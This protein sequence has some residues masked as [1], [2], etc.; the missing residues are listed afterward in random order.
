MVSLPLSLQRK[1]YRGLISDVARRAHEYNLDAGKVQDWINSQ[2]IR[3]GSSII[4]YS[5]VSRETGVRIERVRMM[6]I[7]A[8]GGGAGIS[9]RANLHSE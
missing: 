3:D 4:H 8:G 1:S 6:M 2:E 7:E 9:V 5:R